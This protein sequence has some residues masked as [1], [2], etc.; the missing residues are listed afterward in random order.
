MQ[1]GHFECDECGCT[2][3]QF[4]AWV[5]FDPSKQEDILVDAEGW[6][7]PFC[8]ECDGET[9]GVWVDWE[10]RQLDLFKKAT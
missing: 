2:D 4:P 3:V 5:W 1:R 7:S 8:P 6:G 9:K 10:E